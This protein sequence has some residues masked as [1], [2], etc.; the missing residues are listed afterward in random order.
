MMTRKTLPIL[1]CMLLLAG[2][3]LAQDSTKAHGIISGKL[4]AIFEA[5]L[6]VVLILIRWF[7]DPKWKTT[8][9]NLTN[10]AGLLQAINA[11]VILIK[12][13]GIPEQWQML[14][15]RGL[16]VLGM[17]FFG[18]H[19]SGMARITSAVGVLMGKPDSELPAP[20]ELPKT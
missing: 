15:A 16:A 7:S 19:H 1:L 3:A 12:P 6:V 10:L 11:V 8:F 4:E 5:G 13:G 2:F 14:A 18:L 17:F 9:F 20:P